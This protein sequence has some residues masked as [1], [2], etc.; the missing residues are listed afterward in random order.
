MEK[1]DYFI[2]TILLH[3]HYPKNC[4]CIYELQIFSIEIIYEIVAKYIICIPM[5]R[6]YIVNKNIRVVNK[7]LLSYIENNNK[8]IEKRLFLFKHWLLNMQQQ[9]ICFLNHYSTLHVD[10]IL[11]Y[12]HVLPLLHGE[13]PMW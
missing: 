3:K 12:E 9:N 10:W 6:G 8:C 7:T 5:N 13:Y 4:Y 11:S 2:C 1:H